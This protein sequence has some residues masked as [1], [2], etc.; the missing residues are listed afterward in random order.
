[1]GVPLL[2]QDALTTDE[3]LLAL[4]SRLYF[5]ENKPQR[6]IKNDPEVAVSV[7]SSPAG[8]EI[9]LD[10]S[11]VGNTPETLKVPPGDHVV[12]LRKHGYKKWERKL[13]IAGELVNIAADLE[14][15]TN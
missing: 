6:D 11:F 2:K 7:A 8:A 14:P 9:E 4:V 3:R 13:R 15:E 1:M 5:I 12:V 10:G